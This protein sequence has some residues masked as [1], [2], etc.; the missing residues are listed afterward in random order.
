MFVHITCIPVYKAATAKQ[1]LVK[2]LAQGLPSE[3]MV[4]PRASVLSSDWLEAICTQANCK[5]VVTKRSRTRHP[6]CVTASDA[7]LFWKPTVVSS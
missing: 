1:Q 4:Q 3:A 2:V 6:A 7:L 5:L